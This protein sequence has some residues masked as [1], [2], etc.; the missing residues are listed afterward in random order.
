[1]KPVILYYGTSL[2]HS[3]QIDTVGFVDKV[4]LTTLN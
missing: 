1:M 4:C 2:D 3:E